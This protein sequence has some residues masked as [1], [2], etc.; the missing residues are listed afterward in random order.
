M[1]IRGML[2]FLS[3]CVFSFPKAYGQACQFNASRGPQNLDAYIE[4]VIHPYKWSG[5]VLSGSGYEEHYSGQGKMPLDL[6]YYRG[7]DITKESLGESKKDFHAL[8]M[9]RLDLTDLVEHN[10]MLDFLPSVVRELQF[11][12]PSDIAVTRSIPCVNDETIKFVDECDVEFS[13]NCYYAA[14]RFHHLISSEAATPYVRAADFEDALNQNF[15]LISCGEKV[16]IGDLMVIYWHGKVLWKKTKSPL[17]A[18]VVMNREFNWGKAS[19]HIE[20]PFGFE[21]TRDQL[22]YYVTQ[23]N[24]LSEL[25]VEYYRRKFQYGP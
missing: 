16:K 13:P 23:G 25:R 10:D 1:R 5:I 22:Q 18:A 8:P 20:D 19:D 24:S 3:V 15:E 21:R 2:F 9:P 14:L 17:H 11:T 6:R 12:D 7:L 4:Q